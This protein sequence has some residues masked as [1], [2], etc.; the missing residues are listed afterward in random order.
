MRVLGILL[1]VVALAMGA[2][3]AWKYPAF[4]RDIEDARARLEGA[5]RIVQTASGPIEYAEVGSGP[6]VL[7]VHGSGGGFDQGLLLAEGLAERGFRVVAMSRFAYLRTPAPADTS[8][9]AQADA[10]AALMDALGIER[11]AIFGVSAGGPSSIEFAVRHGERCAALVLMV[12][13]AFMP[14]D[15]PRTG[16]EI[17]PTTERVL[18]TLAG[19]DLAFWLGMKFAPDTLVRTVLG[20][21]PEVLAR[22][23][24]AE[25]MR[26]DTFMRGILPVSARVQGIVADSMV[27]PALGPFDL[28]RIAAPALVIGARDD[29]YGTFAPSQYTAAHIPRARFVFYPEGGHMLVGHY[30]DAMSEIAAFLQPGKIGGAVERYATPPGS[31]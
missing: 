19:S 25:R 5:S 1:A 20:T 21:P 11:A 12:P 16:P 27:G 18:I 13:I 22:A 3:A 24:E 2:F 14:R 4:R 15:A 28:A 29:L 9:A 26:V 17:S 8:A 30:R 10:H 6:V 23:S 7:V 31:N